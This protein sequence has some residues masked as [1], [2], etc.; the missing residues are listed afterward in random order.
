MAVSPALFRR[1]VYADFSLDEMIAGLSPRLPGAL[2][3]ATFQLKEGDAKAADVTLATA[4]AT[5][6]DDVNHWHHLVAAAIQLKRE[7]PDRAIKALDRAIAHKTCDARSRILAYAALR[8]LGRAGDPVVEG[9]VVE[10]PS[11]GGRDLLG[12]YADDTV[13]YLVSH[14]ATFVWDRPDSRLDEPVRALLDA[15]RADVAGFVDA[16]PPPDLP[17]GH[18]RLTLLTHAGPRVRQESIDDLSGG[19]PGTMVFARATQLLEAVL[20]VAK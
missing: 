11:Q 15:A 5:R 6:P 18:A 20:A 7:R 1:L 17:E 8:G 3:E 4:M 16:V 19:S 12:A 2:R 14:G 9:V 10:V 13:R